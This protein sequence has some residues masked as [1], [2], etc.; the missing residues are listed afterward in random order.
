MHER[1]RHLATEPD[2]ARAAQCI[3]EKLHAVTRQH[4]KYCVSESSVLTSD[5]NKANS[6]KAKAK[7]KAKARQYKA[8]AKL[9]VR[10]YY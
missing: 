6:V 9:E 1:D 7:A 4:V 10:V 8:K 5:V 2:T 3:V